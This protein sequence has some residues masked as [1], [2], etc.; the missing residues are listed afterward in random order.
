VNIPLMR[1]SRALLDETIAAADAMPAA[2]RLA[3][4]LA[5]DG[6]RAALDALEHLATRFEGARRH[7]LLA[8]DALRR[9]L[10]ESRQTI[11]EG[12]GR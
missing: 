12:A 8:G 1:G 11:N 3:D 2:V 7:A 10:A 5:R 4:R 6:H 9:E